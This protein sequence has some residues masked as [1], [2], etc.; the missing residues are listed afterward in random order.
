MTVYQGASRPAAWR[1]MLMGATLLL[2]TTLTTVNAVAAEPSNPAQQTELGLYVTATEA[3]QRL[4]QDERAVLVDVRA[5]QEIMFVGIATP[6]RFHVPSMLPDT[7]SFDHERQTFVMAPNPDFLATL[8]GQL[9]AAGISK[10]DPILVT[11]RSGTRSAPAV[12]QLASV[13]YTRVYS[14]VDGF[15]GEF[16]EVDGRPVHGAGWRHSGLPW[17][18][19]LDP[20]LITVP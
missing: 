19:H 16:D 15:E 18:Y 10:D 8:T 4:Q 6:T 9:E 7:S 5:P 14:V 20:A 13:G 12:N 2:G 11:C 1:G 17:T 3:W